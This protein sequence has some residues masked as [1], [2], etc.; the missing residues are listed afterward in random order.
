MDNENYDIQKKIS[1]FTQKD[2]GVKSREEAREILRNCGILND[3][4]RIAPEYTELVVE[5]KD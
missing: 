2:L 5:T 4:N 3:D 1:E